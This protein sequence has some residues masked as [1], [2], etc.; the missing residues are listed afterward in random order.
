[1]SREF[2][3]FS[4]DFGLESI[5]ALGFDLTGRHIQMNSY[6]NRVFEFELENTMDSLIAKFYRP[7]RWSVEAIHEEHDFLYELSSQGIP[8]ISP[9][10]L[11]ND[12]TT[13]ETQGIISVLFPKARGRLLQEVLP[14]DL[15]SLG[16]LL[17]RIHNIGAQK[18]SK[19]RHSLN[20]ETFGYK[21]IE[22][23]KD[24]IVPEVRTR[25]EKAALDIIHFAE[26][27]LDEAQFIRIHGDCH[28]GNILQ[29]DP[30]EG[31]KEFFLIDFDD[32]C[33]GPPVQDF[34]MLF[35]ELDSRKEEDLI[36]SGY[37]ELRDF[38]LSS[39]ELINALRGLRILNYAAWI[40]KRWQDP[41]FKQTFPFFRDYNYWAEE[42]EALE[43]ISWSL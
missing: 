8:V 41:F 25:Y 18:H 38:D 23:L 40:A 15:V 10:K 19:F 33:M 26:D 2:F 1:M 14:S 37:T 27:S 4:P 3:N 34:W 29:T 12:E 11:S 31:Q 36:L 42:T 5:E 24:W 28:R 43:K 16:R 9:L 30:K 35:S 17:A 21:N 22:F 39:L 32:F 7:N 6:E 13:F 20:A